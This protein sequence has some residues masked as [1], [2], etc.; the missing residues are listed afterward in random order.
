MLPRY[1]LPTRESGR[2]INLETKPKQVEA[3]L[4]RLPLSNPS[5]AADI[6]A[7]YLA[8][9]NQINVAQDTRAKIIE[10]MTPVVEDIVASL[11]EQYGSVPLPLQPKQQRNAD[12]ARRLLRE[13]ADN[14]KTLLLDWLK[15]RFHLFGGN[16]VPL[17][18]Q[19]I[20]LALQAILEISL[21]PMTPSRK[22]FGSI[23]T[24]PTIT[25]CATGCGNRSPKAARKM[26]SIE[27]IYKSTL[28]LA[29]A[30]PYRFPQAELPW[31]KDIITR[32]GNLA[33]I[34]PAKNRSKAIPACSSSR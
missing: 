17:Y 24:R 29:L 7:D 27:Q 20:L 5:E 14:Y 34:Y 9:L 3:W 12:L 31:A 28:L 11:Y 32:F 8:T 16:P 2:N 4:T 6:M 19:R 23:C 13:L 21:K 22:G 26:L 25:R 33:T 30:D 10:R 18:L 1:V 15:R